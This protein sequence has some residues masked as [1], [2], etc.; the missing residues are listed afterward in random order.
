LAFELLR[1]HYRKYGFRLRFE[2]A[3]MRQILL[4]IPLCFTGL[5]TYTLWLGYR[6]G[7]P[8]AFSHNMI[9][10]NVIPGGHLDLRNL[11][12]FRHVV[13]GIPYALTTQFW[14]GPFSIGLAMFIVLPFLLWI[15]RG[16]M[17]PAFAFFAILMFCFFDF[18]G[19]HGPTQMMDIGRHLMAVFPLTVLI[20]LVLDPGAVD[21]YARAVVMPGSAAA[22]TMTWH[23]L[24][25]LPL[26]M[27]IVT[28]AWLFW[29]FTLL[30]FEGVFV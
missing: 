4:L 3:F 17:H 1:R 24:C 13:A 23:F 9:A 19:H 28:F 10:W 14:D 15:C 8:L 7:D 11:L 29:R 6:F 21:R 20:A 16:K 2:S 18:V 26:L 22:P 27:L 12:T 25:S 30:F 5:A